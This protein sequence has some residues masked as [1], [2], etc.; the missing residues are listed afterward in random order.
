MILHLV[1]PLPMSAKNHQ[2]LQR[3]LAPV[4]QSVSSSY[5]IPSFSNHPHNFFSVTQGII[6]PSRAALSTTWLRICC[7]GWCNV[8]LTVENAAWIFIFRPGVGHGT[9]DRHIPG[10]QRWLRAGR[11]RRTVGHGWLSLSAEV[12]NKELF[13][14]RPLAIIYQLIV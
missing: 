13:W 6:K 12:L 4:R 10:R 8:T 9:V 2:V 5:C 1:F 3:C 14:M 11:Q 7:L